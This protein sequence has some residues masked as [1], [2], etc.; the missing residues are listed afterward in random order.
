M[1]NQE[2]QELKNKKENLREESLEQL[3]EPDVYDDVNQITLELRPGAG[4]T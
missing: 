4:G 1:L 2:I 3:I